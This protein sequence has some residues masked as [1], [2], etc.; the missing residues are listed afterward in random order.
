MRYFVKSER[1]ETPSEIK[2]I[3]PV[4]GSQ[5]ISA[6]SD[7]FYRLRRKSLALWR[8]LSFINEN[9]CFPLTA[10]VE[11]PLLTTIPKFC[12]VF[13]DFLLE[14]IVNVTNCSVSAL[15][16]NY[17][18]IFDFVNRKML[19]FVLKRIIGKVPFSLVF[20]SDDIKEATW[21]K[22]QFRAYGAR[23]YFYVIIPLCCRRFKAS[24]PLI[25][26]VTKKRI[27]KLTFKQPNYFLGV[28]IDNEEVINNLKQVQ[29]DML[30]FSPAL[31]SVVVPINNAHV[32]LLVFFLDEEHCLHDAKEAMQNAF[33]KFR[34]K[35][36]CSFDL[37]IEGVDSFKNNVVYARILED[38][39]FQ[40]LQI[41]KATFE[42]EGIMSQ[43]DR[44]FLPH[45]T[46][47]IAID[48]EAEKPRKWILSLRFCLATR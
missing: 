43:D 19:Q 10:F 32:T 11:N 42:E 5:I 36:I 25:T 3:E 2:I 47:S 45:L 35:N 1:K 48:A 37:T 6:C 23:K 33:D 28:K 24:R 31:K 8:N 39:G 18:L 7:P 44:K 40:S 15:R 14:I 12:I 17:L 13:A 16:R 21:A 27:E 34:A 9:S 38:A 20:R 4:S 30:N 46:F 41:L 29:N 26:I 22:V